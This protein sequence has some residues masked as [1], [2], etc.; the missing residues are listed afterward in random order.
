MV[1]FLCFGFTLWMNTV[2]DNILP[3]ERITYYCQGKS[4]RIADFDAEALS[5]NIINLISSADDKMRL[6][7][8]SDLIKEVKKENES[9]EIRF[10]SICAFESKLLGKYK[11]KGL[12]IPLCGKYVGDESSPSAIIFVANQKGYISGPLGISA[13]LPYVNGIR[14]S[15]LGED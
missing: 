4:E 14:A 2:M 8:S 10:T 6:Y 9:V 11:L 13:G 15:I 7:V 3:I 1:V 5:Q 12:L